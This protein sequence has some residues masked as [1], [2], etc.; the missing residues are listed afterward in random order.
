[1]LRCFAE[2][3]RIIILSGEIFLIAATLHLLSTSN[4]SV[5]STVALLVATYNSTEKPEPGHSIRDPY[6]LSTTSVEAA[7]TSTITVLEIKQELG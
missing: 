4:H 2:N 1:V 3:F 6:D 7:N 5:G